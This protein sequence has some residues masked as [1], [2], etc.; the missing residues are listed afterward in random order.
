MTGSAQQIASA[1]REFKVIYQK[2]EG[3]QPGSYSMDHSAGT[4]VFDPQGKLRLYVGYGQGAE[5][6]AHDF[7]LL[8]QRS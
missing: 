7:A 2:V 1:A 5:V 8:L 6:F 3:S 4:F